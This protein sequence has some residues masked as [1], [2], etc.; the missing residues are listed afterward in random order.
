MWTTPYEQINKIKRQLV[1]SLEYS[2]NMKILS[3]FAAIALADD[4]T[5][6]DPEAMAYCK[7]KLDGFYQ[8]VKDCES[9]F[10][11]WDNGKCPI[12]IH[13]GEIFHWTCFK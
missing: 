6:H 13:C 2:T 3:I 8:N 11:C 9:F 12:E 10:F 7:G 4:E 1:N 5:P